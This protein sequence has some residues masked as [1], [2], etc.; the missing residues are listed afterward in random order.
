MIRRHRL[1]IA[2]VLVAAVAL[3][4]RQVASVWNGR[5]LPS[6]SGNGCGA[7]LMKGVT[8]AADPTDPR[9]VW[10]ETTAV[11]FELRWWPGTRV[12]FGSPSRI[13]TS[14]GAVAARI[15]ET[16][17]LTGGFLESS[18]VFSVCQVD[19]RWPLL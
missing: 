2:L 12:V 14:T 16:V 15:G 7:M 10:V 1:V 13:V 11:Q 18:T 8:L 6:F 5:E 9:L 17:D 3:G 19:G 4:V